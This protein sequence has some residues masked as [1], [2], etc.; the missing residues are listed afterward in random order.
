MLPDSS[1]CDVLP[2]LLLPNYKENQYIL[3]CY[4]KPEMHQVIIFYSEGPVD[5]PSTPT[6][7]ICGTGRVLYGQ[8]G[9]G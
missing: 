9:S 7:S 1:D 5:I 3:R 6:M 4:N 2:G 8:W